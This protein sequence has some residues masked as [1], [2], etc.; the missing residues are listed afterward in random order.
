VFD[1]RADDI[2]RLSDLFVDAT[3]HNPDDELPE[4]RDNP[5]VLALPPYTDVQAIIQ[6]MTMAFAVAHSDEYRKWT[7]VE[8]KI[9]AVAG[10]IP[11][12]RIL[13]PVHVALLD[14]VHGALRSH[15]SGVIPTRALQKS[16]QANYDATQRGRPTPIT[17]PAEAHAECVSVFALSGSGK[18]TATLMVLST[19]PM[20]IHHSQFKGTLAHFTQ[21][22]WLLV[23][24]PYNGSVLAMLEDIVCWF[25]AMLDTPYRK[26]MRSKPTIPEYISKIRE[27]FRK[28]H[29]GLVVLDEIQNT[30]NAADGRHLVDFLTTLF[31]AC[32]CAFIFL[33][34]TEA[35]TILSKKLRWG[36]RAAS[37]GVIGIA[38]FE[39]DDEWQQFVKAL[40][41]VDFLPQPPSDV[42]GVSEALF[43]VSA[44][45]AG[46]AKLAWRITQ[47][48]CLRAG[49]EMITADWIRDA[50][51]GAFSLVDGLLDALRRRD[52]KTLWDLY[53]LAVD[54]AD[55]LQS[56]IQ[57]EVFGRRLHEEYGYDQFRDDFAA[58]VATMIGVGCPEIDAEKIVK[59]IIVNQRVT[60]RADILRLALD[61]FAGHPDSGTAPGQS[62]P[63]MRQPARTSRPRPARKQARH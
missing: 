51:H 23:T 11:K 18:T 17:R 25:D 22:V 10:R 8:R 44:G 59:D 31:N 14:W 15:Y 41:A 3:Y 38:P 35:R 47:F 19:L 21:V 42:N 27:I 48:E 2:F 62:G 40:I 16:M 32:S 50:V 60:S 13:L 28:H 55:A 61:T 37:G 6:G 29:V 54:E 57:A 1:P 20:I 56:R 45:L 4:Y 24:C 30:L 9:M 63:K 36:R 46:F 58:C 5:L 39:Q 53:D 34:T 12:L 49:V 43:E 33:G 26:E 52:H 7:S